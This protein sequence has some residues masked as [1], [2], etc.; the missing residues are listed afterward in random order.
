MEKKEKK[1]PH[2]LL[3]HPVIAY[4]AD[5]PRAGIITGYNDETDCADV[6]VFLPG[7][8]VALAVCIHA[9]QLELVGGN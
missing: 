9:K 8:G 6:A 1:A 3:G 5:E 2:A 4:V 7:N